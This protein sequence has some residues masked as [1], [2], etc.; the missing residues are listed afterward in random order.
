LQEEVE[1]LT[2]A[3]SIETSEQDPQT[4]VV[5]VSGSLLSSSSSTELY[6]TYSILFTYEDLDSSGNLCSPR[7][8]FTISIDL[9]NGIASSDVSSDSWRLYLNYW[10]EKDESFHGFGE[11]FTY[12]N[13]KGRVLPILVSEQGL[14]RGEEPITNDLNTNTAAGSGGYWY[15]TYAPKAMYITNKNRSMFF[16]ESVVMIFDMTL[17]NNVQLEVWSTSL[18]GYIFSGNS[19][20][21]YY[22]S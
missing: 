19:W 7:I 4:G 20:Y 14:G 13:L 5:T 21:C 8:S 17:D 1:Y 22:S 3:I 2:D 15:T 12:F 9:S 10:S 16:D 6:G 11:S 18:S